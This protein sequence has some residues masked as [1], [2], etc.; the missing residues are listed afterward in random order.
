MRGIL[1]TGNMPHLLFHGPAGT[2]KTSL[3]L[4][5]AKELYGPKFYRKRI[6]ELNASDD[7]GIKVVRDKIKTF[8]KLIPTKNPNP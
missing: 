4:A 8:A 3:I 5:F 7:R 6:L 2:G 1:K